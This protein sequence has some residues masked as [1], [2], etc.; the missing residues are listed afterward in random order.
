MHDY[1]CHSR[2]TCHPGL[3]L[4]VATLCGRVLDRSRTL[5]LSDPRS[6]RR[7]SAV[8]KF[9]TSCWSSPLTGTAF[10]PP[11]RTIPRVWTGFPRPSGT[12][13]SSDFCWAISLR[14][15][16]L[17]LTAFAGPS[18]PHWVR[19]RDFV[20]I[21]S[22]IRPRTDGN[23][24]FDAASH[25]TPA[26]SRLTALRFRSKRSLT[27]CFHQ[28]SPHGRRSSP[29]CRSL[30]WPVLRPTLLLLRFRVP[31]VRAPL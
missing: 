21:P 28:T 10:P 8:P 6:E 25:L 18:R 15:F 27:Y 4:R 1:L 20:T 14:P 11:R 17:L 29:E 13:Q 31:S 26:T 5:P 9:S 3:E 30:G 2:G 7:F 22:P 12:M 16:V 19:P 23:R 24:A